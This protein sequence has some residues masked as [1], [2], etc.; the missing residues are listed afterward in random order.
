MWACCG[1]KGVVWILFIKFERFKFSMDQWSWRESPTPYVW[2]DILRIYY[3][4][5]G[6]TTITPYLCFSLSLSLFS[7]CHSIFIFLSYAPKQPLLCQLHLPLFITHTL[8]IKTS[9]PFKSTNNNHHS[10]QHLQYLYYNH[11]YKLFISFKHS[12]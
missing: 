6:K 11:Y 10:T 4:Y 7:T 9:L 3:M 5:I 2:W 12:K 1:D 8:F